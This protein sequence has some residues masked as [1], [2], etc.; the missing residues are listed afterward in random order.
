MRRN[1]SSRRR[2]GDRPP[3]EQETILLTPRPELY[4]LLSAFYAL[5][6]NDVYMMAPKESDIRGYD[7]YRQQ[8]LLH[9]LWNR[10]HNTLTAQVQGTLHV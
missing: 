7:H 8:R 5:S 6:V 1:A 4:P 9:C 10:Y 2:S 3:S